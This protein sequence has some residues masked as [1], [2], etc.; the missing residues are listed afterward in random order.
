MQLVDVYIAVVL[1]ELHVY[2]VYELYSVH[3]LFIIQYTIYMLSHCASRTV[4]GVYCGTPSI[5]EI[6]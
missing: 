2:S 1:K 3:V 4:Y 5:H 6:L